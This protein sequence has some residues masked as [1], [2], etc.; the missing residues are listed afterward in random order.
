MI[1]LPPPIA[2]D[3]TS[4]TM[5]L[6]F[7][8]GTATQTVMIPII[9]NNVVEGTESFTVSLRTRDSAVMLIPHTTTVTIQDDDS[10]I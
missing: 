7:N 4:V 6:T 8:A 3:Y 2:T 5:V 1:F 10:E 9:G